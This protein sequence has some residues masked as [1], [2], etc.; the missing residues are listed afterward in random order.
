MKNNHLTGCLNVSS[1]NENE[2]LI[3]GKS[4]TTPLT[5]LLRHISV[6]PMTPWGWL[7]CDLW[8]NTV[9]WNGRRRKWQDHCWII[10]GAPASSSAMNER[11]DR[12]CTVPCCRM[13][14]LR[15][16]WSFAHIHLYCLYIDTV[17]EGLFFYVMPLIYWHWLKNESKAWALFKSEAI[18]WELVHVSSSVLLTQTLWSLF[19]NFFES[20]LRCNNKKPALIHNGGV[21][22]IAHVAHH[23]C[24]KLHFILIQ[25]QLYSKTWRE[26]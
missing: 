21:V 23:L 24:N 14:F 3:M 18:I 22:C 17:L 16:D 9:D 15:F 12:G 1:D 6:Y 25:L 19:P 20:P 26:V 10:V 5:C 11:W 13:I 7:D 4:P 8:I 2:S